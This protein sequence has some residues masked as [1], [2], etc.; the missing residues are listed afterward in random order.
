MK[1]IIL[2]ISS[3]FIILTL[4]ACGFAKTTYIGTGEI[5]KKK[6]V[7]ENKAYSFNLKDV[8]FEDLSANI[9]LK[10]S[11]VEESYVMVKTNENILSEISISNDSNNIKITGNKNHRYSTSSFEIYLVNIKVNSFN[12]STGIQFANEE[13]TLSEEVN[14]YISGALD[15]NLNLEGVKRISIDTSGAA[16]IQ[17]PNVSL[18]KVSLSVSGALDIVGNG[19]C[20]TGNIKVSGASKVE[21]GELVFKE[22]SAKVSGSMIINATVTDTLNL[23]G[24]GYLT[25]YI[26]GDPKIN[27]SFS[28]LLTIKPLAI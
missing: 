17:M 3:V 15:A 12:V 4:T 27:K 22:L 24:S 1:K 13:N 23:D 28:G 26:K 10:N 16:N 20:N 2:I 14:I 25:L 7:L 5:L 9:Y 11:D 8:Y 21:F 18:E 6:E 19:Y